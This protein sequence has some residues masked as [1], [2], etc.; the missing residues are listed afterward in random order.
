M[1]SPSI[2]CVAVVL[3]AAAQ[4]APANAAEDL[5]VEAQRRGERIEVRASAFIAAPA[6]LAWAV[7][8]DYERLPR[9]IPG[10]TRSSVRKREADRA[11]VEQTGEARFLLFSFPIE[12]TLEVVESP[13]RWISSRAVAGNVRM[14]IGRYDLYPDPG[15]GGVLLRYYGLIEPDFDLPPLVGTAALR[16]TAQEQFTAMVTEI[17]RRAAAAR[18]R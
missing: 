7:L 5:V 6:P 2:A 10:I 17:E 13:M 11:L 15:R 12:V 18:A 14:M 3:A 9:F 4:A 1:P 16:G 8:A